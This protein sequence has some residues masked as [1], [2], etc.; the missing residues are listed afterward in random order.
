MKA[1]E[2]SLSDCE[3]IDYGREKRTRRREWRSSDSDSDSGGSCSSGQGGRSQR[4]KYETRKSTT[5]RGGT[6]GSG[7]SS[8]GSKNSKGSKKQVTST[9]RSCVPLLVEPEVPLG[10][11]EGVA[12]G[13]SFIVSL[14]SNCHISTGSDAQLERGSR[15]G[16]SMY[17]L[18]ACP[19]LRRKRQDDKEGEEDSILK[20]RH[21]VTNSHDKVGVS[22]S[23]TDDIIK[24]SMDNLKRK[25][26][27]LNPD[28]SDDGNNP[29]ITQ[30]PVFLH[31]LA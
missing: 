29:N 14:T 17:M 22:N 3:T 4:R 24:R 30:P 16:R 12:N 5:S 31:S 8:K 20:K 11:G 7:T 13:R 1:K 27:E 28:Y 6:T 15:N 18:P 9:R 23:W 26:P 19:A 10:G 25:F 21:D 2:L